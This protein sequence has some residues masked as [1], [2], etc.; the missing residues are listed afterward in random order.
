MFLGRKQA[1]LYKK[2]IKETQ[3][4]PMETTLFTLKFVT[5]KDLNADSKGSIDSNINTLIFQLYT[6]NRGKS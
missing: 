5:N 1:A 4:R 6:Q 2:D 3:N